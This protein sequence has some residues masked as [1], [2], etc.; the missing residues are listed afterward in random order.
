[1]VS[2]LKA[3]SDFDGVLKDMQNAL[4][5]AENTF[6]PD[7]PNVAHSASAISSLLL[8]KGDLTGALQY[9]CRALNISQT[10]YGPHHP[11]TQ[12]ITQSV[13]FI[14]SERAKRS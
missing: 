4:A 5:L 1:M 6:G 3:E 7:H 10:V 8:I 12:M 9:L 11:E 13:R 2:T 14:E